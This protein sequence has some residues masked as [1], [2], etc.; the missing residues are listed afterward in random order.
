MKMWDCDKI[1]QSLSDVEA[2]VKVE[3]SAPCLHIH[4]KVPQIFRLRKQRSNNQW[5][6]IKSEIPVTFRMMCRL[7]ESLM[8]A[9][10]Q[11]LD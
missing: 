1:G 6:L 9:K 10:I 7:N 2:A 5:R 11:M 3:T 4:Y 8:N